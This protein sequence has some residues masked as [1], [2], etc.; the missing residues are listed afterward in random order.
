MEAYLTFGDCDPAAD[1][2]SSVGDASA[3]SEVA[4][5]SVLDSRPRPI[6]GCVVSAREVALVSR[7]VLVPSALVAA[8]ELDDVFVGPVVLLPPLLLLL[9]VVVSELESS[10]STAVFLA[11]P[12]WG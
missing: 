6:S 5:A 9:V 1:S 11:K 4:L 2:S 3:A 12:V 10:V 8:A 7:V